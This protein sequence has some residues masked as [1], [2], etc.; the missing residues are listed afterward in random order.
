MFGEGGAG[1]NCN[2]LVFA[3]QDDAGAGSAN[4]DNEA[5]ARAA[6]DN[7]E[8]AVAIGTEIQPGT[9]SGRIRIAFDLGVADLEV[10]RDTTDEPWTEGAGDAVGVVRPRLHHAVGLEAEGRVSIGRSAGVGRAAD[11]RVG[12]GDR[13]VLRGAPGRPQVRHVH[14]ADAMPDVR[15]LAAVLDVGVAAAQVG[16]ADAAARILCQR[17]FYIGIEQVIEIRAAGAIATG[18]INAP[19]S[20]R[21][22]RPTAPGWPWPGPAAAGRA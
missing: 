21:E 9:R 6:M 4:L 14:A 8:S 11:A 7:V 13:V 10:A 16:A 18:H 3:R 17:T 20:G 5:A 1:D 12:D 19:P 2:P 22:P 15:T